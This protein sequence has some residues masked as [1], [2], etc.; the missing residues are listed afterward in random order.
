MAVDKAV[1]A[2]ADIT[3]R[4]K[5]YDFH[6]QSFK[7]LLIESLYTSMLKLESLYEQT[8]VISGPVGRIQICDLVWI[9]DREDI[10]ECYYW[11]SWAV[12]QG[13][14]HCCLSIPGKVS[15]LPPN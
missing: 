14:Y 1:V 15:L 6:R 12:L 7:L 5:V 10:L 3:H 9:V 11:Q 2:S 4:S 8:A 13:A